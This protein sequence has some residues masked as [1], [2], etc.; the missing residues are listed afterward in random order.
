MN[1]FLSPLHR[2][3]SRLS[4]VGAGPGDPDLITLKAIKALQKADVIL[5]DAL[6][7]PVLLE[8][9]SPQ[10]ELIFVGKRSGQPSM[11]QEAI[12]QL[13]VEKAIEKGHVLR[14]K[15]GDPIVFARATEEIQA[16]ETRGI[17]V[18]IIPGIS[19]ALSLAALQNVPL[20][21]RGLSRGFWVMTATTEEEKLAQD[22]HLG[23]Q[24]SSTLVIL[25]G[26][27]KLA[28][29][30]RL[31]LKAGKKDIPVMIIQNG[32]REN[33]QKVLAPMEEIVQKVNAYQLGAPALIIIGEVVKL[34]PEYGQDEIY[35]E[36]IK[37]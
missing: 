19:S 10:A 3:N 16:A 33:E 35:L 31:F 8:Y 18:E 25:M 9:A 6:V 30:Q 1:T 26:M 24:S 2:P 34:H 21:S 15:G 12:N 27:R 22:I 36:T 14:L 32:S 37:H 20:T 28:Q 17:P 5:Y 29:I 11:K 4:L 13:I 23:L 7:N